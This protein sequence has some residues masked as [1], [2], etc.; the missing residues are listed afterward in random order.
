MIYYQFFFQACDIGDYCDIAD[1]KIAVTDIN[2]NYPKFVF[3]DVGTVLKF[4]I[5]VSFLIVV[6]SIFIYSGAR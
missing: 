5:E 2:N 6:P 1:F 3:P 4:N